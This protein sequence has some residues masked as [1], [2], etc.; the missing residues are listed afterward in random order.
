MIFQIAILGTSPN[1]TKCA[2]NNIFIGK[3]LYHL[4][5]MAKTGIHLENLN[6]TL[7][8]LNIFPNMDHIK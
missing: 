5:G 8:Q 1:Y 7:Y 4:K 2:M 6:L 3:N